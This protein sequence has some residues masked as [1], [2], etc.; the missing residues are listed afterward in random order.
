[1][2]GAGLT[3]G[4]AM[5]EHPLL[6]PQQLL[7]DVKSV[8]PQQDISVNYLESCESTNLECMRSATHGQVVIAEQQ[9]AGRG[10]RGNTWVSPRTRNIYCSIGIEKTLNPALLGMV[11]L[12]VGVSIAQVLEH[13]G[14]ES[15][16]LKWPNDILW[17]GKKLG[18]ILIENRAYETER[19]FLV[20][21]LGLN[22]QLDQD[23]RS[24]IEQ[25]VAC[26]HE[27]GYGH[28]SRQQLL[29]QLIS[30]IVDSIARLDADSSSQVLDEFRNYD[31]MQNQ[32]VIVK[33]HSDTLPGQYLGVAANGMVRIATQQGEQSFA[34]AEIS[35]RRSD[36]AVD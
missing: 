29:A 22:M 19:F 15:I 3:A 4:N 11:S 18:G 27:A 33:T 13:S 23:H 2:A 35:L 6:D 30:R 5:S 25:P 14:I 9:T 36:H 17:R 28:L 8:L 1:M 10:R 16:G 12:Q 26:L 31:V 32:T 34:A 24:G 20:I 21:G 7:M